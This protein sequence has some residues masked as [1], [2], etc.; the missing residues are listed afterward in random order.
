M[1]SNPYES[2]RYV[3][4]YLL[5]HYGTPPQ[6]CPF[7]FIDSTA[8]HFHSEIAKRFLL[9]LNSPLPISAL[10]VGCAA[11]RFSFELAKIAH[12]VTGVD[13]SKA[14]IQAAR[15]IQRKLSIT[16]WREEESGSFTKVKVQLPKDLQR[17]KVQFQTGDAMDLSHFAKKPYNIVAAINLICRLS[18][19]SKFIRQ[20]PHLVLP[21]GQLI[22]ASP[23]SWS[24]T[25]TPKKHW[26][27]TNNLDALLSSNFH[28]NHRFDLPFLIREH[29]RKYQLVF[30]EVSAWIRR[31]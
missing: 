5:F 1:S 14:L 3:N 13:Y 6:L 30:S 2:K 9:P 19:P 8:L 25:Y 24:L 15:K 7:N 17:A 11:G 27:H 22:L 16:V 18:N 10:D 23:H 20:L 31:C 28:L 26:L 29:E 4:D 21:G 12:F